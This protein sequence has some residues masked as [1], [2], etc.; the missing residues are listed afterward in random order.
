MKKW[1]ES[2]KDIF[3]E[4]T[5]ILMEEKED[6]QRIRSLVQ[7]DLMRPKS[8][9][10][11]LDQLNLVADEFTDYIDVIVDENQVQLRHGTRNAEGEAVY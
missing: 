8:A 7:Q 11:Y 4:T 1:R 10:F 6:W 5:G 2:R 3:E 9:M